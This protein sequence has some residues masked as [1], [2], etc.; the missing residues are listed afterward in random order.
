VPIV[1]QTSLELDLLVAEW[2]GHITMADWRTT[3]ERY[4]ADA[5]Y[6]PGRTELIDLSGVTHLDAGFH[7]I[8]GALNSV[9]AQ[10]PGTTVRTRTLIIA[11]GDVVFGLGR[12]YQTLADNADGIRVEIH[13]DPADALAALGL[14]FASVPELLQEGGFLPHASRTPATDGP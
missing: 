11:P 12:M 10:Q 14:A 8:W 9:N 7:A 6:R 1:F 5:H 3:F 2:S 4:L 13:R